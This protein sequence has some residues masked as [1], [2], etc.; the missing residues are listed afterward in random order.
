MHDEPDIAALLKDLTVRLD[1]VSETPRIEAELLL[2]RAID[3]PRAYLFAHPEDVPDDGARERLESTAARRLA[4]EPMAY[5]TGSREFWSM[6]LAV[7]PATLVP[8]PET[9]VLVERVL[10]A[11][12][13]RAACRVLDLG[14]GCGA[15]A[16]A[17]ARERP[18]AE[19]VAVDISPDAIAVAALNARE[20]KLPNVRV[21]VGDWITPVADDVF[22]IVV[23]NPPYVRD[24]DPAL[25]ELSFEPHAALAAG[26][27][28]LA[29]IRRIASDCARILGPGGLLALEHGADQQ[30]AVDA[31][32]RQHGWTEI[33]CKSDYAGLPR[34]SSA[35]RPPI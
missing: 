23:S 17:I 14:T 16:L 19:V 20:L 4:G 13:R 18:L 15:I 11:T 2:A 5:I 8:R 27:D 25:D 32:L 28:G 7:T 3:M 12:P 34:V 35:R 6:P 31:L 1:G 10:M 26:P 22:D 33:E 30:A 9:E 21:L 24:D 29:A